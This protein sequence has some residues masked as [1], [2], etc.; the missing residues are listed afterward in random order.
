MVTNKTTSD[1][2][3]HQ[4]EYANQLLA[5]GLMGLT[6]KSASSPMKHNPPSRIKYPGEPQTV[7]PNTE[8]A[9]VVPFG[10][11]PWA[12]LSA[13]ALQNWYVTSS[14]AL[15]TLGAEEPDAF[16]GL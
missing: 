8:N 2:C 7:Q 4:T 16:S 10:R 3:E 1:C 15:L 13:L 6:Q 5:L 14:L 9:G 11:L 12:L